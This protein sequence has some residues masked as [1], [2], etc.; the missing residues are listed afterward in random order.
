[1]ARPGAKRTSAAIVPITMTR[2]I[3][4]G[5]VRAW[6]VRLFSSSTISTRGQ[7]KASGEPVT[8]TAW[9]FLEPNNCCGGEDFGEL[10]NDYQWNDVGPNHTWMAV[11][12]V[13]AAPTEVPEPTSLFLLGTGVM[14]LVAKAR[15]R[16]QR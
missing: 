8:F 15:R 4:V 12:E 10:A 11:A 7:W 9:R 13:G 1:M 2:R 16:K 6:A 3:L 5:T 14:G